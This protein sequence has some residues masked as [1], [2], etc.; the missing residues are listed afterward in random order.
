MTEAL[1]QFA[2]FASALADA[3][4]PVLR[5][6]FRTPLDV[7]AKSDMSPVTIADRDA[8]A[9]LRQ[10][11]E[12]R[13]PDHGIIG[14]EYGA[15]RENAS[16]VWVLDPIDGTQAYI[17]GM[18]IF[19][20]LIA[21]VVD[22]VPAVGVIDQPIL[23]ERWLGVS[24]QGTHFNGNKVTASAC[25]A[26]GDAAL[27][28]THPSMFDPPADSAKF[29]GLSAACGR[30]RFGGDCYAYGLLA[31]GHVDLVVEAKLQPYDFMA[32][33]PVIE[34]AGGIA[35]NWAGGALDAGSDG[36]MLAAA[37]AGLRDLAL[38]YLAE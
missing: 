1:K 5:K 15:V 21:L 24:G 18:P 10:K 2:D 14:E 6:H 16:H 25:A 22:G 36:H 17:T 7:A 19:G 11:I 28:A 33:I 26:L 34:G 31:S 35:C 12:E 29:A 9:L 8:E 4:G 30:T 20:T 27:Y 13:F 23:G 32:L 3:S 37:N 38:E